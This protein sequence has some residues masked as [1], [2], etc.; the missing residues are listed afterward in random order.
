[1]KVN[2]WIFWLILLVYSI[3]ST[4]FFALTVASMEWGG[5]GMV[6]T[7]G[8]TYVITL[9]TIFFINIIT[10][11]YKNDGNLMISKKFLMILLLVKGT[12]LITNLALGQNLSYLLDELLSYRSS[13]ILFP[14]DAQ[15]LFILLVLYIL[16]YIVVG[17][18]LGVKLIIKSIKSI[19]KKD[20]RI[21]RS[22]IA[23]ILPLVVQFAILF[24]SLIY[25]DSIIN[26]S[27]TCSSKWLMVNLSVYSYIITFIVFIIHSYNG[28][29]F[30][31]ILRNIKLQSIILRNIKLQALITILIISSILNIP[32]ILV[33]IL[34][35][36]IYLGYY[37]GLIIITIPVLLLTKVNS[38]SK[39]NLLSYLFKIRWLLLYY[40][41]FWIPVI[42]Y[43]WWL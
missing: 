22:N 43:V 25:C 32:F 38:E 21:K 11:F 1:M 35:V 31:I 33:D 29:F 42:Y 39:Y 17:I 28:I 19:I 10:Y 34:D 2:K 37:M 36:G 4:L 30:S 26:N 8:Y 13:F 27:I 16:I 9:I 12:A 14:F 41:L 24:I 15:I 40:I 23:L 3:L 18:V 20:I 5:L 7:F 6:V